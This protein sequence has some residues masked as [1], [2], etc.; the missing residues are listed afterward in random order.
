M[1]IYLETLNKE[2]QCIPY[3]Y[4]CIFNKI[5]NPWGYPLK[6]ML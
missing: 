5:A 2:M 3:L 1:K 4:T 6:K